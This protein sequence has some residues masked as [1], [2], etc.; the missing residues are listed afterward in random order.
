MGMTVPK[1]VTNREIL[2]SAL[3]AAANAAAAALVKNPETSGAATKARDAAPLDAL[4]NSPRG[5]RSRL[6]CLRHEWF[7]SSKEPVR[8]R[9]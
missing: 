9:V 5:R 2:A 3:V 6:R 4:V 8:H 7:S 1:T